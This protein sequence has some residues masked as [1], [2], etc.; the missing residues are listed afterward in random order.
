MDIQLM[1][2]GNFVMLIMPG[3][4]TTMSGRRMRSEFS[5]LYEVY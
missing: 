3:E 2:V 5:L 4:L 1:R